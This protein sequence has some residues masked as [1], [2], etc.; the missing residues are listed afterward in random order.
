LAAQNI[1]GR[2][3]IYGRVEDGATR[4]PVAGAL[5]FTV[6]STTTVV[7]D[8]LGTFAIPLGPGGPLAVYAEQLGYLSQRFDLDASAPSRLVVL[9]LEPAPFELET[10]TVTAEADLARL[11]R[12]VESRA[13]AYGFGSV[14]SLDRTRL[15][16]Y[17]NGATVLDVIRTRAPRITECYDGSGGLCTRSRWVSFQ[18]AYPQAQVLVCV[19]ELR[20]LSPMNELSNLSIESIA[21]VEIFG[22]SSVRVYTIDWM[23]RQ[24]RI[25]HTNVVP[26]W[27][28]C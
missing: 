21:R 23:L 28:G 13:N 26:L 10:L 19:D 11:I 24:A 22:R 5:V 18:S 27:M 12:G 8:S 7:A 14:V 9:R 6:D 17:G 3:V 25:G 4:E 1:S 16:R 15:E 2:V 20:S